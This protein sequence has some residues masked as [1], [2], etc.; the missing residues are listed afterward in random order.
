VSI[1]VS[2]RSSQR[3]FSLIEAAFATV[4]A[5]T[6]AA[7]AVA[8][9]RVARDRANTRVLDAER[10]FVTDG[11]QK[12]FRAQCHAGALP[13]SVSVATLIAQGYLARQP[14]NVWGASWA[15]A[16]SGAAPRSTQVSAT[17]TATL[18]QAS[19]IGVEL[20]AT[21]VSAT[22]LT[23]QNLIPVAPTTGDANTM[24][25]KSM[26]ENPTC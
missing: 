1:R 20:K 8:G 14:K 24:L 3:G 10:L 19:E 4:I 7:A 5:I 26:Y 9:L 12:Y 15:V 25:F 2:T 18:A 11:A 22:T 16:Y 17:L 23:W 6:V 13:T 21:T